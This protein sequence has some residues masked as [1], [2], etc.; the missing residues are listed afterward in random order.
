MG[1]REKFIPSSETEQQKRANLIT[2]YIETRVIGENTSLGKEDE[3]QIS[4]FYNNFSPR[5]KADILYSKVMAYTFDKQAEHA[6]KIETEQK[7]GNFEVEPTDPYLISEIKILL[8]DQEVKKIFSQT[9]SEARID[10]KK[11]RLSELGSL[12]K[13]LTDEIQEKEKIYKEIERNIHIHK[14]TGQG[15]ISSAQSRMA[16]LA[17]HITSLE[18]RKEAI[19]QLDGF[20]KISENTDAVA[21]FQYET[22]KEYKKQLDKGFV[23]LPSR[24]KIHQGTVSAILNHRWPVLIG[25]AGSGKSEQ[26]DAAA[27]ELTGYLPTK[28]PCESVTGEV[29]LIKDNAIDPETGGSYEKYGPLL[30]AFTG[31]DD[32]RQTVPSVSNGRIVR[33]DESGRLGPKAYPIIKEARQQKAGD[34]F[35]GRKVLPGAGAIWTT[36]P[37]GLRYPDRHAPDPA[38]RRELAEIK[39]DYPDMSIESPELYDFAVSALFDENN[40]IA[41][42]KEELAPAYEKKDIPED[43]REILNDG[44]IVIAEDEIVENMADARH[45]ALWRFCSAIKSLQESFVYGNSDV[46]KYPDTLLRCKDDIDSNGKEITYIT[47]DGSGTPLTLSTS[48]VTLGELSSWMKGFNER[49]QK[50]DKEF[51]V[52][53]LTEWLNFEVKTYLKQADKADKARIEAIFRYFGFLDATTIPNVKRAKPLTPKDIGYLSPRVPRPVYIEKPKIEIADEK[54]KKETK[55]KKEVKEYVEKQVVDSSGNTLLV[56]EE[57]LE[58]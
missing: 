55:E 56:Q 2:R 54:E 27:L 12:W 46:E 24:K 35:Y 19:E 14:I 17:E 49:R 34:F 32:S 16:M 5:E 26:A 44:S 37:V 18:K 38:M 52:D 45:G 23:W 39:V 8:S 57:E 28:V 40:H 3:K 31:Y 9:Y 4:E 33:F 15:K 6:R 36:N 13:S 43:K 53:T 29:Q 47:T 50:Q 22:F 7:G 58:L 41:V 48:T 11:N 20:P 10:A 30:Q 25:E 1:Q 21:Q 51:R 42:A